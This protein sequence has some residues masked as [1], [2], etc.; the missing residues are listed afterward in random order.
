[1]HVEHQTYS[2]RLKSCLRE[3]QSFC[4]II[5][6]FKQQEIVERN[7]NLANLYLLMAENQF[8][9]GL[10][11]NASSFLDRAKSSLTKALKLERKQEMKEKNKSSL[12]LD[13]LEY[14]NKTRIGIIKL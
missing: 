13:K 1:M 11:V 7:G 9:L 2:D 8:R 5:E 3:Y 4:K 12:D 14:G 10:F 6:K